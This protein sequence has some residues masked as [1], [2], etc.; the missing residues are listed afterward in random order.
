MKKTKIIACVG[1]SRFCSNQ[2]QEKLQ[3][4]LENFKEQG[5]EEI[6]FCCEIF[7]HLIESAC[8]VTPLRV[9]VKNEDGKI[10]YFNQ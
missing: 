7:R 10:Q 6:I 1:C 9:G 8:L 4:M 3:S 2:D 5:Y